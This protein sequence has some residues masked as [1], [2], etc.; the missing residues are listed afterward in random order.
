LTRTG[1][2]SCRCT[3]RSLLDYAGDVPTDDERTRVENA[4]RSLERAYDWGVDS[5][6]SDGPQ[7]RTPVLYRLLAVLL[8][9]PVRR[10]SARPSTDAEE[11]VEE[12][13]SFG[14][15]EETT[16]DT[17]DAFVYLTSDLAN[18]VLGAEQALFNNI[19]EVNGVEVEGGLDGVFEVRERRTGFLGRAGNIVHHSAPRDNF[20]ETDAAEAF[21]ENPVSE[22]SPMFMGFKSGTQTTSPTRTASLSRRDRSRAVPSHRFHGRRST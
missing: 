10:T 8:R 3:T 22:N 9:T 20:E 15:A 21:D 11:L 6:G 18:A 13:G 2:P 1:T 14:A 17:Y 5:Q 7:R 4:F 19:D 16:P 12:L